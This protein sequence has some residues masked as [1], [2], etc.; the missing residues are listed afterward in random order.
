[1]R[2]ASVDSDCILLLFIILKRHDI[3]K[4]ML[5]FKCE[6]YSVN[7]VSPFSAVICVDYNTDN[8]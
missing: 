2:I 6:E 5:V 3:I 7:A 1:M 8:H 4:L